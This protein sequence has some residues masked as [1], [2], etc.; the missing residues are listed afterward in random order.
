MDQEMTRWLHNPVLRGFEPDPSITRWRGRYLVATSTFEWFPGVR[1][2]ASDDL[3]HWETVGHV[4]TTQEQLDLTGVPDSGGIWAPSISVVDD[5][6]WV[7]YTIVRTSGAAAKDL[8]NYL[9]TAP[10]P[11][12]PW[13]APVPLGSRGF[14]A[15][16]LHDD[17]GR[18]WLACVQWDPRPGHRRFAGISVQEYD[19]ER[20]RLV[21]EATVVLRSD[22]LIE[23]PNLYRHDGRV[24]L[25]VAQGGTGWNH[26]IAMARADNPLGPYAW[27]PQ[28]SLLTSRDDPSLPLQ[29][30]GHGELVQAP[31][32]EWYLVHLASRAVTDGT[33]RWCPLGRETCLQRVAWDQDGW[34]RLADDEGRPL[35]STAPRTT[36]LAGRGAGRAVDETPGAELVTPDLYD[37][38]DAPV[39]D[40]RTWSTLRRPADPAWADLRSRP[41]WLRLRGGQSGA[42]RFAQ[43][44][45]ATRIK[46]PHA[47]VETVLEVRP[48]SARQRAGLALWYDA[49]GSHGVYVT[50]DD[51]G[52]RVVLAESETP[53]GAVVHGQP[54]VLA[55]D[56]VVRLRV[57]LDGAFV[58]MWCSADDGLTWTPCATT[59]SRVV[60]EDYPGLLRFTGV[61]AAVRA[62][63]HDGTGLLA[64]FGEVSVRYLAPRA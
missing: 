61:M 29:K 59:S 13:S 12:G 10:S 43:S 25:M 41:G 50:T 47:E 51:D 44:L 6:L 22:E 18:H 63:D 42:S 49:V 31:T 34:L 24:Y 7:A 19:H 26:G 1:L 11:Q 21:G 54:L 27:D 55:D 53:E 33:D 35:A 60:S 30:A 48:T 8:D 36:V 2:H 62:D 64:D 45:V 3:V 15:S 28:R 38:F 58:E 16:L 40:T 14:D 9:V 37:A 23:G 52:R 17:D 57:R 4:L 5:E 32:G 20:R 39:L 56:A 46:E